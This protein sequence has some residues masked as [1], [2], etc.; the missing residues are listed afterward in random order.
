MRYT[1]SLK[2]NRE[3]RRLYSKGKTA[4]HPLLAVYCRKNRRLRGVNRLGISVS[5][6]LGKAVW[7]NRA[8][9]R[10]REAYRMSEPALGKGY[11][12]V[13]VAR[14]GVVG[15]GFPDL[16]RAMSKCLVRAGATGKESE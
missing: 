16:A 6:K 9:R 5:V 2:D 8:K 12:I 1:V 15:A 13:V 7:R 11:D 10:L 4:A 14:Q 3:F